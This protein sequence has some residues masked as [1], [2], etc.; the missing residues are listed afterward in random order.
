MPSYQQSP[1]VNITE[2]DLTGFITARGSVIGAYAD[3]FRWGPVNEIVTITNENE[4][5]NTFGKPDDNTAISF[6]SAANFLAYTNEIKIVRSADLSNA[7]NATSNSDVSIVIPNE[8]NFIQSQGISNETKINAGPFVA[9]YPGSIGNSLRYSLCDANSAAFSAW[10]Y[11]TIFTD[12]PG[13]SDHVSIRGGAND[14]IHLVV[15]DAG[16]LFSG[17]P[18][19]IL[20]KYSNL[21]RST[22]AKN[23]SGKSIF[24]QS[25]INETSKYIR[26]VSD[27]IK[28]R[29]LANVSFNTGAYSNSGNVYLTLTGGGIVFSQ[30]NV[31]VSI[32]SQ[33]NLINSIVI[34]NQGSYSR[35]P[36]IASLI[37]PNG[38]TS[39]SFTCNLFPQYKET[40]SG[41]STV[42][43]I[44]WSL[45][46][47]S[48]IKNTSVLGTGSVYGAAQ[49]LRA[50]Q[51]R[52][53]GTAF[54]TL[55]NDDIL[56]EFRVS[57]P[58]NPDTRAQ[59]E[60]FDTVISGGIPF[61][62]PVSINLANTTINPNF[63][64][65]PNHNPAW[66]GMYF[67]P[68]GTKLFALEAS[69]TV[70]V[71]SDKVYE[72]DTDLTPWNLQALKCKANAFCNVST[73]TG[74]PFALDFK[75]DGTRMYIGASVPD[76][77]Y[78]YSLSTPWQVNTASFV[79]TTLIRSTPTTTSDMV[80]NGIKF[81]EN[82]SALLVLDDQLTTSDEKIYLYRLTD[83]WNVSSIVLPPIST[84][85][86]NGASSPSSQD[87]YISP[88]QE[89]L[90]VLND[91]DDTMSQYSIRIGNPNYSSNSTENYYTTGPFTVTLGGGADAVPFEGNVTTAYSYFENSEQID[92]GLVITG[93][94]NVNVE[95]SLISSLI[96]TREDCIIF[97]SPK[98]TDVLNSSGQEAAAIAATRS[99]INNSS[100]AFMDSGWKYQYDRYNDVYRWI[101]LNAD[102]AGICA[103]TSFD[104]QDWFSPGG[105]KRGIIKNI[106]RLAY[107]PKKNDRDYLYDK[108]INPVITFDNLGFVLYG[109]KTLSRRVGA[110][111]RINVRRLFIVLKR[112]LVGISKYY[113][114]ELNDDVTRR[115][116]TN[117]MEPYLR[118]VQ[119][120]RGILDFRLVCDETNNPPD[121][122][123]A[124]Q[125]V[126]DIY[127]RPN[128]SINYIQLNFI[129]SKTSVS[130]REVTQD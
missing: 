87:L 17:T 18:G 67:T 5:V 113:L 110:F 31:Q 126:V 82:G 89:N 62:V 4:L 26:C 121:I 130:F 111:D 124:N 63:V 13:T 34:N 37:A 35:A 107:N 30:A 80:I 8:L 9:K 33:S 27:P 119:G 127:I 56:R 3:N 118:D 97:I 7:K 25:V 38:D 105:L 125:L 98:F 39:A 104:Y 14:E 81:I 76:N 96:N 100:Y 46:D 68:D 54:Y 129:A 1:G 83:A 73:Q 20:E 36:Q 115:Q 90:Y 78:E 28:P 22:L 123:D 95:N 24:Y 29:P 128:K 48:F 94:H 41:F 70:S 120:R 51:W 65:S 84:L 44:N 99:Q 114:F 58:W 106:E 112:A 19:T 79:R 15:I 101:P 40:S 45:D 102:I 75:P 92:I 69:A 122:V 53:D 60:Y 108:Q 88:D 59:V 47:A 117:I 116:L 6:F 32:N 55:S 57:E 16:G 61:I 109:D 93:N 91:T 85:T 66:A 86:I 21:S 52:P 2:I 43:L 50:L 23:G 49:T 72:Y 74:S 77:I 64:G 12:A 103:K 71:Y 10:Q 11:S 42:H